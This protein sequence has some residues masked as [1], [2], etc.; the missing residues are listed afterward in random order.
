MTQTLEYYAGGAVYW[1][2]WFREE[3]KAIHGGREVRKLLTRS[4]RRLLNREGLIVKAQHKSK[5]GRHYELTQKA[6]QVLNLEAK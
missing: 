1:A 4:E 5:R 3:L 6:L 2:E